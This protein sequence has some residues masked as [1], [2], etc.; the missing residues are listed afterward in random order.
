MHISKNTSKWVMDLQ[1]PFHI[2]VHTSNFS[3]LKL[4]SAKFLISYKAIIRDLY[5]VKYFKQYYI[6]LKS[7][8][9]CVAEE[10]LQTPL[11]TRTHTHHDTITGIV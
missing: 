11:H 2:Y 5:W 3:T 4:I 10:F 6:R 7:K 1:K 8:I 9:G